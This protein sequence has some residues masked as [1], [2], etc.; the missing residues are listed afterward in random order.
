MYLPLTCVFVCH[1]TVAR[2]YADNILKTF[3]VGC[4]IVLNCCVSSAFLGVPLAL[5]GLLGVLLVVGSTCLFNSKA[6]KPGAERM[7]A[8]QP[9]EQQ[10]HTAREGRRSH[11]L[12]N[13]IV[14]A[15][16]ETEPL[17]L[18]ENALG[19]G[20]GGAWDNTPRGSPDAEEGGSAHAGSPMADEASR[21]RSSPR[22]YTPHSPRGYH[23]PAVSPPTGST[24]GSERAH[25]HRQF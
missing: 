5:Q 25:T 14:F 17:T 13:E 4:S 2:R 18:K 24:N 7:G 8:G 12:R 3:A 10:M 20:G 16:E 6:L 1:P 11:D 19:G 9:R 23:P 15:D 21:R 22:G